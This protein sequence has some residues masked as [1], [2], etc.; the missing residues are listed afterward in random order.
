VVS[1]EPKD[2]RSANQATQI[3]SQPRSENFGIANEATQID[4][5]PRSDGMRTKPFNSM[6]SRAAK[7]FGIQSRSN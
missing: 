1:R 2:F 6:I 5:Q 7:I 4:G 3:D